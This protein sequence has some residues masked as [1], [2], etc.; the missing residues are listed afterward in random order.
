MKTN[1]I[2]EMDDSSLK[3]ILSI[4]CDEKVTRSKAFQII[5]TISLHYESKFK[6]MLESVECNDYSIITKFN[7]MMEGSEVLKSEYK[8]VNFIK[9]S[10]YF[11]ESISHTIH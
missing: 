11:I 5:K 7:S 9:N 1:I 8:L 3:M 4:Y 2:L 6:N 10:K